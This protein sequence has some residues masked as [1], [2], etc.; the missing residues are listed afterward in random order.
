MIEAPFK[1]GKI[2]VG[3]LAPDGVERARHGHLQI[4]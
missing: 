2:S 4:A 3:M 1:G